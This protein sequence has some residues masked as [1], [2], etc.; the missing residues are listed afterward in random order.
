[1]TESEPEDE[2][3]SGL[4]I[5][6]DH[7]ILKYRIEELL[8]VV[9]EFLL[10]GSFELLLG[11]C[12]SSRALEHAWDG[13]LTEFQ[14]IPPFSDE[15][16]AAMESACLTPGRVNHWDGQ[17]TRTEQIQIR[18]EIKTS[19]SDRLDK[20]RRGEI[21]SPPDCPKDRQGSGK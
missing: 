19:L 6:V 4:E 18:D 5:E 16:E 15:I 21:P 3:I 12:A 8:K 20:F 10:A 14:Q 1:M 11:I 17:E 9:D 13:Y 2:S 7:D